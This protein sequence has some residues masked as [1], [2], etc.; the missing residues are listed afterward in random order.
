MEKASHFFK[1]SIINPIHSSMRERRDGAMVFGTI[2]GMGSYSLLTPIVNMPNLQR[3]ESWNEMTTMQSDGR[4]Y[5]ASLD[6][7][8]FP[9]R[10]FL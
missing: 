9:N 2:D 6:L 3:R 7:V 1:D 8:V 5:I 10:V 4:F